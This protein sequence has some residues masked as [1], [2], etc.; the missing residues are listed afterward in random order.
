[1]PEAHKSTP[2]RVGQI[3]MVKGKKVRVDK[4]LPDGKYEGTIVR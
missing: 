4:L 2:Y 1:V 3:V